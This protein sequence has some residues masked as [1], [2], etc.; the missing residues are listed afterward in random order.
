MNAASYVQG[1]LLRTH[2]LRSEQVYLS[3]NSSPIMPDSKPP[4]DSTSTPLDPS[5]AEAPRLL[6]KTT[7][8][9]FNEQTNYVPTKIIITVCRVK[10]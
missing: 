6:E 9:E 10:L 4:C 8:S 3:F 1:F 5:L 7:P 2:L